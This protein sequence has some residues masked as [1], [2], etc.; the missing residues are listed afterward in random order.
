M[1]EATRLRFVGLD[2]HC[3]SIAIAAAQPDGWP[4][5]ALVTAPNHERWFT[6]KSTWGPAPQA[7]L[8]QWEREKKSDHQA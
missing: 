5:D 7:W 8:A 2:V 3:D 6:G 1:N 4:A